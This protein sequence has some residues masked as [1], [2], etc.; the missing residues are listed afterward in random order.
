MP[1]WLL[2]LQSMCST[3]LITKHNPLTPSNAERTGA[4]SSRKGSSPVPYGAP[5]AHCH[6]TFLFLLSLLPWQLPRRFFFH[7]S[8]SRFLSPGHPI[9]SEDLTTIEH[10]LLSLHTQS[11]P[12]SDLQTCFIRHWY[13]KI[14]ADLMSPIIPTTRA[15]LPPF[16]LMSLH[17]NLGLS[18]LLPNSYLINNHVLNTT[19]KS[20][21]DL[22]LLFIPLLLW[23]FRP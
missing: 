3:D 16:N 19:S 22:S 4:I 14:T 7:H 17:I 11:K 1:A 13:L 2:T 18:P 20:P 8:S 5:L 23:W 21:L 9:H 6:A 10:W 15:L 12:L